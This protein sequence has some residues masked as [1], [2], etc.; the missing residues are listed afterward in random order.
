MK[1]HYPYRANA[2][3]A[4]FQ[5]ISK[6]LMAYVVLIALL[7]LNS[8]SYF[9]NDADYNLDKQIERQ[10]V[11]QELISEPAVEEKMT[12]GEYE[13]LGD[14]F[15]LRGDLNR[16]Y[17]YYI[18]GLGIEPDNV[19]II[20]KQC[21]LLLKK[22]KFIEAEAVYEKLIAMNSEDSVALE[23]RA[24]AYF[25]LGKFVEAEQD[26]FAALEIN[27]E[28]YRSHEFLGLI[29]S[30]QQKYDQAINRFKTALAYQ[31]RDVT[32][33]NNLAVTYYLNGDFKEAVRLFKALVKISNNRKI[34]NNLA[35]AYF[36]LGFY[37]EAM[38]SFKRGSENIAVAYNN[39]G[40]EFLTIKKYREAILAFEKAIDL[41]PKF[42]PSAQKNLDIAKHELSNAV[43][44][45][46][47]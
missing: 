5:H 41:Y 11:E 13:E 43:T 25:G 46:N 17:I 1:N 27:S 12:A 24:K 23:G 10:Q 22:S 3:P 15:L 35:L 38:D 26:F 34:Y 29:Y 28:Q 9:Q 8:C 44:D 30:R 33:S 31:P 7:F 20:H 19:S 40:Y 45:T 42:Y 47:Y 4:L 37:E 32:I 18:K 36:Q 6:Q 39:M 14:S 16:A 2:F 21:T